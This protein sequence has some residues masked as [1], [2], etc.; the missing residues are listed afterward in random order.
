MNTVPSINKYLLDLIVASRISAAEKT[1]DP[2]TIA[3]AH[4]DYDG[5]VETDVQFSTPIRNPKTGK[6]SINLTCVKRNWALKNI[7][8]NT[9]SIDALSRAKQ[10]GVNN[11]ETLDKIDIPSLVYVAE[12]KQRYLVVEKDSNSVDAITL[13]GYSFPASAL[14]TV[15]YDEPKTAY[16]AVGHI[17]VNHPIVTGRFLLNYILRSTDKP[18]VQDIDSKDPSDVKPTEENTNPA[19]DEKTLEQTKGSDTTVV[20]DKPE[21]ADTSQ[22]Q[23]D[24][25]SDETVD[26]SQE[27]KT[28]QLNKNKSNKK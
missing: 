21:D 19:N 13:T 1:G 23:L 27:N 9:G 25:N 3:K 14:T 5:I 10:Q 4:R 17:D 11:L 24:D 15:I 16:K 8:F 7:T 28:E 6:Y 2:K 12:N 20:S 18:P 26:N 22:E